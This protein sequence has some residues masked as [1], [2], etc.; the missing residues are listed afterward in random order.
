M[1]ILP[2]QFRPTH[3]HVDKDNGDAVPY[4]MLDYPRMKLPDG[5]WVSGVLY[6]NSDNLLCTRTLENFSQRFIPL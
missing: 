6:R 2:A 1:L 3:T 4:E 5:S